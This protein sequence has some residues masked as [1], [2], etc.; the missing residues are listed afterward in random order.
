MW[1]R[2]F[3]DFEKEAKALIAKHLPLP[4]FDFVIKA[5]HAFNL[6]DSRGV[7]SVTER[8]GYIARIRDLARLIA[9]AYVA[10]REKLGFPLLKNQKEAKLPTVRKISPKFN[11]AKARDFLLEIG[12]E[13]LPATFIPI[14]CRNLEKAMRGLLSSHNLDHSAVQVYRNPAAP[15]NPRERFKR[16]FRP[17]GHRTARSRVSLRLR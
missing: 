13:Q 16:G 12:S 2:H 17:Q 14:G 7:I 10:S 9:I 6:L 15:C 1:A 5:S 11:P 3:D 4:A 8:T